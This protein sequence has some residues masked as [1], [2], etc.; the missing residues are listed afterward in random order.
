MFESVSCWACG[1]L[2]GLRGNDHRVCSVGER[3]VLAF[4]DA[5]VLHVVRVAFSLE[6]ISIEESDTAII[7][8]S[9]E[10]DTGN[11]IDSEALCSELPAGV[12]ALIQRIP[13]NPAML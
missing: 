9:E 1:C 5:E 12:L 3:D 7:I 2:L 11:A 6:V 13:F 8:S 4:V 10:G